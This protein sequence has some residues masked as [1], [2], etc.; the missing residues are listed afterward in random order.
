MSEK[1]K[2]DT[3]AILEQSRKSKEKPHSKAMDRKL[4][5]SKKN[6]KFNKVNFNG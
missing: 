5:K 6:A 3:K 4:G 1:K 2:I